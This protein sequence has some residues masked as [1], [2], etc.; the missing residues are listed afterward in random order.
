[1]NVAL[2]ER[3]LDACIGQRIVHL[4][5]HQGIEHDAMLNQH[6]V[7]HE[8]VDAAVAEIAEYHAEAAVVDHRAT[9][10]RVRCLILLVER[11]E[12]VDEHLPHMVDVGAV[13][14]AYGQLHQR[15][16]G[17]AG[18]VAEVLAEQRLVEERYRT[19][20]DGGNLRALVG[21]ALHVA[22][23]AIALYVVAHAHAACHQRYAVEE[24]LEQVL[25]GE[26]K[27]SGKAG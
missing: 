11:V 7:L 13:R 6:P 18:E 4:L 19:A 3:Y 10:V 23:R 27:T 12:V 21:D 24:V 5:L 2:R 15:V 20:V 16:V 17:G 25:H 14:H 22:E 26:A 9:H 8:Q 1:M